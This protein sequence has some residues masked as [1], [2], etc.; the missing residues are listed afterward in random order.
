MNK[1]GTIIKEVESLM[2]QI[3]MNDIPERDKLEDNHT[4][5]NMDF[6]RGGDVSVLMHLSQRPKPDRFLSL[7]HI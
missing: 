6:W 1:K 3:L 4:L 5:K 7:I 2:V